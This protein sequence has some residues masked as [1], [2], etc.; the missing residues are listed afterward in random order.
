MQFSY[1][2]LLW[3]QTKAGNLSV[4]MKKRAGRQAIRWRNDGYWSH[5]RRGLRCGRQAENDHHHTPT[6][7]CFEN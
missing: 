5:Q 1:N 7:G 2:L 3:P 4:V 6:D